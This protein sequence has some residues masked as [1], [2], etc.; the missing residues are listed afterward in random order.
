M[1]LPSNEEQ[2]QQPNSRVHVQ[3][4][5]EHV[6]Q[7]RQN[8]AYSLLGKVIIATFFW[9][10]FHTHYSLFL[11]LKKAYPIAY[12][13]YLLSLILYAPSIVLTYI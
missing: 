8:Q 5:E 6:E 9:L 3:M 13:Y 4:T 1:V 2:P 10:Y 7:T 11:Q 12:Y